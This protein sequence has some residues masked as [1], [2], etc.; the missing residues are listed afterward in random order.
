MVGYPQRGNPILG[1]VEGSSGETGPQKAPAL[2][3]TQRPYTTLA[4]AKAPATPARP[5]SSRKVR[6][7]SRTA[8]RTRR[9]RS[10]A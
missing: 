5:T 7:R 8:R 2:D 6:R 3:L 10:P 9:S 1:L 4:Y